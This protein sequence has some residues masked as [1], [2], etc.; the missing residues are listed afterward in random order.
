MKLSHEIVEKIKSAGSPDEVLAIAKECNVEM[1]PD[2]AKSYF[3]Q[4][5]SHELDDDLLDG[6]AGGI[7]QIIN[8]SSSRL[9]VYDGSNI[10]Y[11]DG[12]RC[13]Q[14]GHDIFTYNHKISGRWTTCKSCNYDMGCVQESEVYAVA[15]GGIQK[16]K[17]C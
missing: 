7:V 9:S 1:T 16:S 6:V 10:K 5:N 13:P 12:R 3:E 8:P 2:E 11:H 4:I 17:G 14:C 15:D